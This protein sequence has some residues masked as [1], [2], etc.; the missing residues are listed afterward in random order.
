MV[1]QMLVEQCGDLQLSCFVCVWA[2][3]YTN[4]SK[5]KTLRVWRSEGAVNV[6]A[7]MLAVP[8]Y[9]PRKGGVVGS[10]ALGD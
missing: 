5:V 7:G 3:R 4:E 9:V 10:K 8:G 1:L 2:G 6:V